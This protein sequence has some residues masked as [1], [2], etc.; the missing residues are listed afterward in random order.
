[1]YYIY[2]IKNLINHKTYVGQRKI[3]KNKTI[4]N[5]NYM[6]SGVYL[7]SAKLKYGVENL[8]RFRKIYSC[9]RYRTTN[10]KYTEWYLYGGRGISSEYYADFMVFYKELF[11][12][13]L[14]H[15]EKYGIKDT[16]LD[17]I[18]CNGNYEKGNV[19]WA[20]CKEQ[21]LNQRRNYEKS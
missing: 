3:P 12:S 14:E 2:E 16:T 6:G 8:K 10:P 7:K 5:D 20:T 19:R 4:N 18:D 9:M 21:V 17:R 11:Q 13:Y 15:I 1:M